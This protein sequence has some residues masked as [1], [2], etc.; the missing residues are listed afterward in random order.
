MKMNEMIFFSDSLFNYDDR[1][2]NNYNKIKNNNNIT[3]KNLPRSHNETV[4]SAQPT[5]KCLPLLDESTDKHIPECEKDVII[6]A[7]FIS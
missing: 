4:L 3:N 1:V 6:D 5:I 2:S 7:D